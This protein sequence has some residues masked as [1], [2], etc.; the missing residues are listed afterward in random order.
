MTAT[1]SEHNYGIDLIKIVSMI[2]IAMLHILRQG[3][4][5]GGCRNPSAQLDTAWLLETGAFCAVNCFALASGYLMVMH[6]FRIS[7]IISLWFQVVF[8]TVLITWI[9]SKLHPAMVTAEIWRRA[10]FPVITNQY[11]YFTAYFCMFFF[12]PVFNAGLCAI[13][14]KELLTVLAAAYILFS[15]IPAVTGNDLFFTKAGYSV[16]WLSLMYICG[17]A[18]RRLNAEQ[19]IHWLPCMF[20]YAV[21]M[22]I[23]WKHRDLISYTFPLIVLGSA[24][25]FLAFAQIRC[26]NRICCTVIRFFVPLAFSVYLI[27]VHPLIWDTVMN[28]HFTAWC[29]L[30]PPDLVRHVIGGAVGI[31]F[32]CSI[33]DIPRYLLFHVVTSAV[34]RL[35]AVHRH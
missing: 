12:T 34:S 16:I 20:V 35:Q 25:L 31:W 21:C 1:D 11:W 32:V 22:Y 18:I 28:R 8:Y 29:R 33:I 6:R 17:G 27:H 15:V 14:K 5:L 23:T 9:F 26:T 19:Y 13:G 30:K 2:C 10:F 7:R 4:I 3:G 24:S